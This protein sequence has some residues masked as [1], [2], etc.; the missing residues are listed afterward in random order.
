MTHF[1]DCRICFTMISKKNCNYVFLVNNKERFS[2]D[3][4][5]SQYG[6]RGDNSYLFFKSKID[7]KELG[8]DIIRKLIAIINGNTFASR[9]QPSPDLEKGVDEPAKFTQGLIKGDPLS[10]AEY[11]PTVEMPVENM[12]IGGGDT[13][14]IMEEA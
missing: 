4:I 10:P 2:L 9:G 1:A 14:K 5:Y 8:E 6:G 3:S 7:A 13:L 12:N 11:M